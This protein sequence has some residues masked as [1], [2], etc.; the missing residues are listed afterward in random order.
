V[1]NPGFQALLKL[2]RDG[3]R[4]W[5]KTT[6]AYRISQRPDYAD[7]APMARALFAAAPDRLIYGSDYPHLSFQQHDTTR[8]FGLLAEW[9]PDPADMRRVLFENPARL[10]SF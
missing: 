5:I 7:I 6:G 10:Y 9:F 3:G 4:A 1:A 8:L 2:L